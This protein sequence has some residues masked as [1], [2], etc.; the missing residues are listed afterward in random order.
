NR[1]RV[2]R[3][4]AEGTG[5]T[6]RL[7]ICRSHVVGEDRLVHL[8]G[9]AQSHA[10]NLHRTHR[11]S[12]AWNES[13]TATVREDSPSFRE[14]GLTIGRIRELVRARKGSESRAS[15]AGSVWLGG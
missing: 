7:H 1:Q 8:D 12:E 10:E 14:C 3:Q 11:V 15:H 6:P 4:L 9:G 2:G 13:R 5:I